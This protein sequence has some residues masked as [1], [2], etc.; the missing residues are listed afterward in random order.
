MKVIYEFDME[1]DKDELKTFQN[2]E[3]YRSAVYE[4]T[5]AIRNYHKYE[6]SEDEGVQYKKLKDLLKTINE[7]LHGMGYWE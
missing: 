7:E 2:A 5:L 4:V 6:E 1:N 3:R